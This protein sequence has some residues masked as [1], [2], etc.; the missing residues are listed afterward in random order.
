MG[1][2]AM[3]NGI[4]PSYGGPLIFHIKDLRQRLG[5][6]EVLLRH[7]LG[8][9]QE[10][11]VAALPI[12][13]DAFDDMAVLMTEVTESRG[14]FRLC[15]TVNEISEARRD[16]AIALLLAPGHLTI[17]D[18]L[19]RLPVFKALGAVMFPMS[20][21][22][23]NLLAEGC[24]EC[25]AGGLTRLGSEAIKR[26][27]DVGILVDVSHLSERAF[28]DAIETTSRP[29]IA[30]HSN[31]RAIC[32]N[33]R[34]LTDEQ[35][36]ALADQGGCVGTSVHPSMLSSDSPTLDT[37]LKHILHFLEIAGED[38]VTIGADFID[39][40][41]ERVLPQLQQGAAIGI[42]HKRHVTV[43]GLSGFSDLSQIPRHL[44]ERG[45]SETAIKKITGANFLALVR[46]VQ[47]S[48]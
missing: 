38:H 12:H 41:I 26:L 42:Y 20:Y 16:G 13:I 1:K 18:Q 6:K 39:Y 9:L 14:A 43:T 37:Y 24:G 23:Q 10:G 25:G 2:E 27:N 8:S 22:S 11:G 40:Q 17:G 48:L 28:W 36:K 3:L 46:T 19:A 29:I 35:V 30:S 4:V 5:E 34:N 7:H 44:G 47:Q 45:L 21:N 33:P 31:S 15:S 32:D